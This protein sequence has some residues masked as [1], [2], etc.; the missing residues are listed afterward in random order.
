M[1]KPVMGLIRTTYK[2]FS[3][4]QKQ[5][6]A[7]VLAHPEKV[8]L[9]SIAELAAA[10][11]V[12]EPTVMRFLHKMNY[13]S[14]QVFRVNIARESAGD[15]GQ[16]LYSDV[17]AGDTGREIM[18]KVIASTKC[19]LEDLL[20]ILDPGLLDTLCREIHRAKQVLI[21]GVGSTYAVAWDFCHKLLKLGINAT[22][23]ND[24]H[25]INIR[26]GSLNPRSSILIAISH[27]GESREILDGVALAKERNCPVF[28]ITSFP[29]SSLAKLAGRTLLSS[30]LETSYRSD[31]LTSRILQLCIIDMAYI[32]LALMG[33]NTSMENINASRV[34]VARNKT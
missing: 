26:C 23:S 30:S 31:A 32:R 6:A 24:P 11:G 16:A 3:Q 17:K 1:D 10:C 18:K 9:L 25:I 34:A 20:A 4:S 28:G 21:I 13:Q 8:I 33:G 7:Y 15:T 5:V 27:S 29:R 14:Y 22:C 12:S 2:A 19:S